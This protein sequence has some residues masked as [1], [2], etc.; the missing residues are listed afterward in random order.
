MKEIKNLQNNSV[1]CSTYHD[2][3]TVDFENSNGFCQ[4]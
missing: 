4:T 2:V 1:L 3:Q